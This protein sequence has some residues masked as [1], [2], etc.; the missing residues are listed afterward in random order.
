MEDAA[1][2]PTREQIRRDTYEPPRVDQNTNRRAWRKISVFENLYSRGEIDWCH[3]KA[4]EK[5]EK[6][7]HGAQGADVRMGTDEGGGHPDCEY[8]RTY[9]AQKLAQAQQMLRPREWLALVDIIM[10]ASLEDVGRKW[11][12]VGTAK[13]ARAQGLVLVYE[14][15]DVLAEFWGL[16]NEKG[17]ARRPAL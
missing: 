17:R 6:T 10:G 14:G 8:P 9:Y 13:I 16:T 12:S 2:S 4:A 11:R 1:L 5:L 7:W 3:L 15:L